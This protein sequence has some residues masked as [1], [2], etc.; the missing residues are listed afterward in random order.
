MHPAE[1]GRV[2]LYVGKEVNEALPHTIDFATGKATY[3]KECIFQASEELA[4]GHLC[5]ELILPEERVLKDSDFFYI[6]QL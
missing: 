6:G 1:P 5:L 4:P 3:G 2:L